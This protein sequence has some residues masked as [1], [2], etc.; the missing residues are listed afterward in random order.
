[1]ITSA[2]TP[3]YY[4]NFIA[5]ELVQ[6]T[7]ILSFFRLFAKFETR[8]KYHRAMRQHWFY[9]YSTVMFAQTMLDM[10]RSIA[11]S[12]GEFYLL[13]YYWWFFAN[14]SMYFYYI[15]ILAIII[16]QFVK[17]LNAMQA[18]ITA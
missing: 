15:M 3:E 12:F 1:M 16:Q 13:P 5:W 2:V 17:N 6:I 18:Q 11:G 4:Q 10:C 8:F 9:W 7:V 14:I